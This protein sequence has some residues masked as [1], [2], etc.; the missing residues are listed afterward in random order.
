MT[1]KQLGNQIKHLRPKGKSLLIGVD[2][3]GGAGKS[4]FAKILSTHLGANVINLDLL[5]KPRAERVNEKQNSEVNI[6]FDWDRIDKEIFHALKHDRDIVYQEYDW[7]LDKLTN[8]YTVALNSPIII[9]G[10]YSLQNKFFNFYDFAVWV[11]ALED[12]R[13][14]RV[15]SRDG[16]HMRPLW[17]Q[18]WLPV[19]RRYLK[20]Q[21]PDKKADLVV[22]G[23]NSDFM[24]NRIEAMKSLNT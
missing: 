20:S 9:E 2:G 21:G 18:A 17:E 1:F 24:N 10:G 8:T 3:G 16:E 12:I 22:D 7:D 13:L 11:E 19:E 5:Y 6:D 4:T 15:L 23:P 14:Q